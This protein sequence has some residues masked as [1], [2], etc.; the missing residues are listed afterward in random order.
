MNHIALS[1]KSD[2]AEHPSQ[3]AYVLHNVTERGK[4]IVPVQAVHT[5]IDGDQPDAF[6][7]QN[8]HDLADFQIVAPQSAH[9]LNDDGFHPSGLDFLHHRQKTGPVKA[10]SRNAVIREVG[11]VR[12]SIPAGVFLQH[13]L[14]VGYAVALA[15]QF[16]IAAQ[17]L[18]QRGDFSFLMAV[19]PEMKML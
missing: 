17:T 15:L 1:K 18:V 14:L 12:K 8:L 19:P 3:I 11:R 6:L 4:I 2:S 13:L 10:G 9:V 7:P 5:V 16:I